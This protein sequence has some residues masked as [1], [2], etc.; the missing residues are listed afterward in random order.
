[1]IMAYVK[2]KDIFNDYGYE[3][4]KNNIYNDYDI[5]ETE[6]NL[7]RIKD[8]KLK[9]LIRWT[10][11]YIQM[12]YILNL[13]LQWWMENASERQWQWMT[14]QTEVICNNECHVNTESV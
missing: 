9:D 2:L 7:Q 10:M 1:M 13:E 12:Q 4:L 3:K 6:S 14:C 5:C 11:A 8:M